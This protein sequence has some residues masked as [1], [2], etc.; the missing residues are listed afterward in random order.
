MTP[1]LYLIYTTSDLWLDRHDAR[2]GPEGQV[3]YP[4]YLTSLGPW[5][6]EAVIDFLAD[7]QPD[8]DPPAAEQ[9]AR[10]LAAPARPWRLRFRPDPPR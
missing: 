1:S 6:R 7:D 10:F 2:V 8:L 9:V 4:D 3:A 5:S